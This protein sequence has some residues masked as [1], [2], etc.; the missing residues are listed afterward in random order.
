MAPRHP[1]GTGLDLRGRR[2]RLGGGI[3]RRVGRLTSG[4]LSGRVHCGIKTVQCPRQPLRCRCGRSGQLAGR[5]LRLRRAVRRRD[6][7]L[8]RLAEIIQRRLNR[9][10]R[11]LRG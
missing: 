6:R 9:V 3:L 1:H 2:G 8:S 11:S 7:L 4:R 10:V 5:F